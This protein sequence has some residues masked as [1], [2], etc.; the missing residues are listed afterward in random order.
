MKVSITFFPND[1][2][3]NARTAKTPNYMRVCFMRA[4]A[5]SRLN[6]E[7]SELDAL[8]WDPIMMRLSERNSSVNHHLN[9][10]EQKFQE[11]INTNATQMPKFNAAYIKN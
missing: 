11:F 5:E 2:K 8:K 1:L 7:L 10:L 6:I 3:K 9:R 4:K